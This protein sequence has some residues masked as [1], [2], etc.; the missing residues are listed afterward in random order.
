MID[1]KEVSKVYDN[2]SV[3]L[4]KINIHIDKENLF[5][6]SEPAAP[7]NR[8]LSSYC[9]MKNCLQREALLLTERK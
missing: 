6:L 7:V 2:G 1:F 9:L 3:A 4:D 8:H 5:F